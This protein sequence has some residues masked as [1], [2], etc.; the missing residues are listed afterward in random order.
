MLKA[1]TIRLMQTP[2]WKN[3][4]VG[5]RGIAQEARARAGE[6]RSTNLVKTTATTIKKNSGK[7]PMA[8]TIIILHPSMAMPCGGALMAL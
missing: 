5:R 8:K 3:G 2:P 1:V 4:S 6:K 7:G